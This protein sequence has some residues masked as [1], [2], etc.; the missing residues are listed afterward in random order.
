LPAHGRRKNSSEAKHEL[1]WLAH[2]VTCKEYQKF[3]Q[4]AC[5]AAA[6]NQE[7]LIARARF[8]WLE[9]HTDTG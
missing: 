8:T 9:L 7:K 4:L 1:I 6:S 2:I 5:S 3:L